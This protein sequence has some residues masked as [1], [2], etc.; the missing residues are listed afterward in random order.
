MSGIPPSPRGIFRASVLAVALIGCADATDEDS[1]PPDVGAA[2][3]PAASYSLSAPIE[4]GERT[5]IFVLG[6]EHLTT[7]GDVFDADLLADLLEALAEW[8]PDL[9]AVE[10]LPP[11]EI[12]RLVAMSADDPEGAAGQ[13]LQ[14]F[15][16]SAAQHAPAAQAALGLDAAQAFARAESVLSVPPGPDDSR[17]RRAL[18]ALAAYDVPNAYLQW[19][20]IPEDDRAA[21]RGTV[22]TTIASFLDAGIDSANEISSIAVALARRLG[23]ERIASIDDHVDDE[24][25]LA[26]GLNEQLMS[27]LQ[28]NPAFDSLVASPY[29]QEAAERLPAA[30]ESGDLLPFYRQMNSS[31]ELQD[32]LVAQWHLFY[33]T[34][35]PSGLDVGRAA[36]WEARNLHIAGRIRAASARVPGGRV[37]VVIGAAH[38]PFLDTY[39]HQMM[40]VVV[41]P[42]AGVL[43]TTEDDERALS[44]EVAAAVAELGSEASRELAATLVGKLQES[45]AAD[46]P[47]GAIEFCSAEGLSLTAEVGRATGFEIKRTS[48]RVRNPAN[49][50]DAL[51]RIA[52]DR[53]ETAAAAGD[54]LPARFVQRTDQGAYR[55]Y[56]PMRVQPL[57]LQCHGS[58][59]EL[60]EGVAEALRGR[61]P[62]D[63]ATGYAVGD[64]RGLIRVT[65]PAAAV[66]RRLAGGAPRGDGS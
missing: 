21:A 40:D 8:D 28:G 30:A 38:K 22:P 55:S 63:A 18:L 57:C 62:D 10:S 25:G 46:G 41:E 5:Q 19:A 14:A 17:A 20:S 51:E 37:L 34:D 24:V 16:A 9:I 53:F 47:A 11:V 15:A 32:D 6:T 35:L 42:S 26:T 45:I 48:N 31:A 7:L 44:P 23:H 43:G 52:L 2:D 27:E 58:N 3:A 61:Y 12:R 13:I 39:L 33:R 65:V 60:G 49:T 54:S 50:P 1:A 4:D 29:F 36:L 59:A 66:D 56:H 64:F